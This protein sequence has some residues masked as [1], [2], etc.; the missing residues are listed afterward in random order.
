[1]AVTCANLTAGESLSGATSYNTASISPP[2]NSLVILT[3]M[4]RT[5]IS[6]E[7]NQPTVTG[8]GLTWVVIGSSV[9]YDTTSSS[10]KKFT[11]FRAMGA[12]PSSGAATI[13]FA[14]QSQTEAVWIVDQFSN[15]D[16]SGT[17]G[18]GAV[19]QSATNKEDAGDGG[20][21]TVTLGAFSSTNNATYGIFTGDSGNANTVGSG[22]AQ[23]GNVGTN[24]I[25]TSEFRNDNDTSV[26]CTLGAAAGACTAGIAIE[27]KAASVTVVKD[28]IQ[29]GFI[30]FAR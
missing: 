2:A 17:N 1:M 16:T 27:I 21:L 3:V 15:M 22:F 19:V 10:R 29:S 4:S 30:P 13:D 5:G 6:T 7:P 23:V 14:G 18:S 20:L 24:N 8:N 25:T 11:S 28:V 26:D 9:Y 12:S